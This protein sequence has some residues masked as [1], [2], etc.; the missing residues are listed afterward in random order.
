MQEIAEGW[1]YVPHA[2]GYLSLWAD[3]AE[4]CGFA[5]CDAAWR[6]GSSSVGRVMS[7]PIF[8]AKLVQMMLDGIGGVFEVKIT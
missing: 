2:T 5:V 3:I 6:A 8:F 1:C 4:R 7:M